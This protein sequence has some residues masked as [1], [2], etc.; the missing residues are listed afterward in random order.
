MSR[1]M[2]ANRDKRAEKMCTFYGVI[3]YTK[4]HF[5]SL[6]PPFCALIFLDIGSSMVSY[7]FRHRSK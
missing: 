4:A 5:P 2:V 6:F 3:M 1:I 7:E